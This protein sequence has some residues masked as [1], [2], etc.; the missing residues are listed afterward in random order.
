MPGRRVA[1]P[2][3]RSKI[4]AAATV[5]TTTGPIS[6]PMPRPSRYRSTPLAVARPNALPPVRTTACASSMS[7]PGWRM[8]VPRVPGAPPRTSQEATVPGGGRTTVHPVS[9]TWSDQWPTRIPSTSV[10][11]GTAQARSV[12]IANRWI[13][14]IAQNSEDGR[15]RIPRGPDDGRPRRVVVGEEHQDGVELLE[16]LDPLGHDDRLVGAVLPKL[17]GVLG[18]PV[19]GRAAHGLACQH[20]PSGVRLNDQRL[21]PLRVPGRRH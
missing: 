3:P 7:V 19:F 9:A 8:S 14:H 20:D 11:D 16:P 17:Q 13:V 5:G 12:E 2:T 10:I 18:A 1:S 6:E 21:M 4:T 15:I